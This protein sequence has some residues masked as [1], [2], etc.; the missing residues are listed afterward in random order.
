MILSFPKVYLFFYDKLER[1]NYT[2]NILEEF[3]KKLHLN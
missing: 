2:I 1:V 3:N